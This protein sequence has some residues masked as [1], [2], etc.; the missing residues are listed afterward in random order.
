MSETK[1]NAVDGDQEVIR[2][3]NVVHAVVVQVDQNVYVQNL[4]RKS[5]VSVV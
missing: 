2:E 3:I 4:T 5:S 1:L